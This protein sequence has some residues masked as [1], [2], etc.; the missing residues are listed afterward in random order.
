MIKVRYD[1]A[2]GLI[3]MALGAAFG[4]GSIGLGLGDLHKPGPGFMPFLTGVLLALLGLFL[5]VQN[6]GKPY[7]RKEGERVSLRPFWAKGA[8]SLIVSFLYAFLLEPLGF[9]VA[10]FLLFFSLFKVMGARKWLTPILVSFLA[11]SASYFIFNVWLRIEFPRGIL[12][13]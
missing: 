10:T 4:I 8:C 13:F 11:V 12:S 2:G 1:G 9:L 7:G 5:T 3:W 6:A